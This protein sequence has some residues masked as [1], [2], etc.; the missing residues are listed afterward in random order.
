[1]SFEEEFKAWLGENYRKVGLMRDAT[2]Q[3]N[4]GHAGYKDGKPHD[5]GSLG[6]N[7]TMAMGGPAVEER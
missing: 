7:D 2:D 1:M 3:M 4:G 6:L 5:F